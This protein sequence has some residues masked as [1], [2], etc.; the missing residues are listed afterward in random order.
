V[1]DPVAAAVVVTVALALFVTDAVLFRRVLAG[2]L[3]GE[4]AAVGPETES[5]ERAAQSEPEPATGPSAV[6]PPRPHLH[7]GTLLAVTE[8]LAARREYYRA[9]LAGR[10]VATYDRIRAE[11]M[12][13]AYTEAL[14]V[15]NSMPRGP[16]SKDGK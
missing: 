12:E 1:V 8:A 6:P 2:A 14:H 15:V 13:E 11:G 5:A 7:P 3:E 9:K 4:D 16:V 10:V